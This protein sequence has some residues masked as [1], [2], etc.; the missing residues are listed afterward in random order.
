MASGTSDGS[1]ENAFLPILGT[2]SKIYS[3]ESESELVLSST[4]HQ[5]SITSSIWRSRFLICDR[6]NC[7]CGATPETMPG[8][9]QYGAGIVAFATDLMISQMVP[10]KLAAQIDIFF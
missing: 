3:S 4:W 7:N 2:K 5:R 10:L 9:L 8:P 6:G 1:T